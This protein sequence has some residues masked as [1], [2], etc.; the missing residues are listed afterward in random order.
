MT[1]EHQALERDNYACRVCGSGSSLHVHH[2]Q[3]RSLLGKD[4]LANYVT[5]CA[6]CHELVHSKKLKLDVQLIDGR[7]E[8]FPKYRGSK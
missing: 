3:Y 8:V 7:M 2:I 1:K 5:L 6:E 4:E